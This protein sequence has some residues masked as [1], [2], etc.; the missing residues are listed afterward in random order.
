MPENSWAARYGRTGRDLFDIDVSCGGAIPGSALALGIA[1]KSGDEL[2]RGIFT[3]GSSTD[4]YPMTDARNHHFVPK[5]YLCGFS[6][7]VKRQAGVF[8]VDRT[9]KATFGATGP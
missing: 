3:T 5:G 4:F 7:G 9:A 2:R 6:H 8:V 1:Q